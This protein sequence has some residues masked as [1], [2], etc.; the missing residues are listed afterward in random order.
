MLCVSPAEL[1]FVVATSGNMDPYYMPRV[2][3]FLTNMTL[4]LPVASG[5]V[6]IAVVTYASA[7]HLEFGLGAFSRTSDIVSAINN[8]TYHGTRSRYSTVCLSVQ[9]RIHTKLIR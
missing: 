4:S 7:P 1:V 5:Q 6:R 2:I 3:E 9:L 8:I